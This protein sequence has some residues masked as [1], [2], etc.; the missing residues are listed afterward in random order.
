[1]RLLS[2]SIASDDRDNALE[3]VVEYDGGQRIQVARLNLTVPAPRDRSIVEAR[4]FAIALTL[5][6]SSA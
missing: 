3:C 1:M 4:T 6:I 2:W 5:S